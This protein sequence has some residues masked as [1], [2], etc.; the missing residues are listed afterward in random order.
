MRLPGRIDR[1]RLDEQRQQWQPALWARIVVL[2]LVVAYLIAFV[3]KNSGD[4]TI[5]FVFGSAAVGLIWLLLLGLGLGILAGIL[6]AQLH[7]RR[8]RKQRG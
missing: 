7:R 3:V 6:L 4:V 1:T 5:D 2:L 8:S